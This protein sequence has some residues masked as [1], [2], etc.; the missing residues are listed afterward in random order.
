MYTCWG[1]KGSKKCIQCH[2]NR[3]TLSAIDGREILCPVCESTG[4]CNVCHGTGMSS[5]KTPEEDLQKLGVPKSLIDKISNTPSTRYG[6]QPSFRK[7]SHNEH[8]IGSAGSRGLSLVSGWKTGL[9]IGYMLIMVGLLLL[10]DN[11]DIIYFRD[12]IKF[13]PILLIGGGIYWLFKKMKESSRDIKK[14]RQEED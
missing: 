7:T 11:L 8:S 6:G 4:V 9:P 13:W 14:I 2:G 3:Y 1:C 5:S 12:L 10:L